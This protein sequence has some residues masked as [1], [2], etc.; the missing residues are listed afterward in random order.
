MDGTYIVHDMQPI[1]TLY[2]LVPI[3][4]ADDKIY[5]VDISHVLRDVQVCH[6][7]CE[8]YLDRIKI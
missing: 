8:K 4:D 6:I 5:L 7:N 1:I 2:E 3:S